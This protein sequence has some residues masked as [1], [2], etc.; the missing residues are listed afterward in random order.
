MTTDT[1]IT[2]ARELRR[3]IRIAPP[4]KVQLRGG[5]EG[6]LV[7]M[8]QDQVMIEW[9][10]HAA[11]DMA[12][13]GVALPNG[14]RLE[15]D[16]KSHD[17]K[18]TPANDTSAKTLID[19]IHQVRKEQHI[20]ICATEDVEATKRD[21]GFDHVTLPHV[22]LPELSWQDIETRRSFLGAAFGAPILITGMTGGIEKAAMIN[23]R[24]AAAAMKFQIPMGVGSQRLALE[25]PEHAGI[26]QLKEKFPTLFLIANVGIAQ[27][28]HDDWQ[29]YCEAAINMIQ[30]D[31]LAIHVNVL[32]ELVQVEGD[33]NFRGVIRRIGEI[34]RAIKIPV[35]IKE[36]GAGLDAKSIQALFNVG[37]RAFDLGGRGGTSWAFI[38]GKRSLNPEIQRLGHLFRDWGI[39]TA[40]ALA[41]AQAL[42]LTNV[43]FVA[44]G[45]IRDGVTALKALY[46]GASMAGI[47]LPLFRAALEDDEG[48]TRELDRIIRELKIAMMCGGTATLPVIS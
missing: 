12:T 44:T 23:E 31:A 8:N 26:F 7:A 33:R 17:Q 39:S 47:G 13:V 45:G 42:Q 35:L 22:A 34:V 24:L 6:S 27:I 30:A 43:E 40:Q 48:P 28:L 18:L 15:L 37:V 16:L 14:K 5:S 46:A 36:V 29:R 20:H 32:Q 2:Q 19:L 9:Q 4:L 25:N 10:D 41:D 38:E 11:F 1:H 21:H 3:L